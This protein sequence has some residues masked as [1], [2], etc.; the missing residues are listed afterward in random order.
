MCVVIIEKSLLGILLANACLKWQCAS[1]GPSG[2]ASTAGIN[3]DRV[4]QVVG[5]SSIETEGLDRDSEVL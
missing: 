1:F 5:G 4:P 2:P 3:P